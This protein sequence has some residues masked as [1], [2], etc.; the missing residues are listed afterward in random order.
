[1]MSLIEEHHWKMLWLYILIEFKVN[2]LYQQK[3]QK[4]GQMCFDNVLSEICFL[5][6]V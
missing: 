5:I 4:I 3:M 6:W 2:L 1:M